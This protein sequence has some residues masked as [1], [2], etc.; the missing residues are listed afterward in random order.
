MRLLN[1]RATVNHLIVMI[2]LKDI[3]L[4]SNIKGTIDSPYELSCTL[5]AHLHITK[6]IR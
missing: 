2:T 1:Y 6:L 5:Y 4:M 3:Q